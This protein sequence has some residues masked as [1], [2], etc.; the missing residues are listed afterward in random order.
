MSDR[1][2]RFFAPGRVY[3][4]ATG[5]GSIDANVLITSWGKE[6]ESRHRVHSPPARQ[7]LRINDTVILTAVVTPARGQRH[8]DWD[9]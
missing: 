5:L 2:L 7:L 4:L 6:H 8:P 3:D 9:R 1:I